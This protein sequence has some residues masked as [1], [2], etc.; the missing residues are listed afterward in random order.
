MTLPPPENALLPVPANRT[1]D[2]ADA[3]DAT[4]ARFAAQAAAL[5]SEAADSAAWRQLLETHAGQSPQQRGQFELR[6]A[7]LLAGG[8]R[9]GHDMLF[10]EAVPFFGWAGEGKGLARLG[11]AGLLLA[12][13]IEAGRDFSGQGPSVRAAQCALYAR[14]REGGEPG[15]E[16]GM[17]EL[18]RL[19]PHLAA[20]SGRYE[21]LTHVIADSAALSRW[22]QAADAAQ[23][24]AEQAAAR[25]RPA[26]ARWL[27]WQPV[28]V[29]VLILWGAAWLVS[30][31]IE[32]GD[33]ADAE[34]NAAQVRQLAPPD[35]DL[36]AIQSHIAYTRPEHF[37]D[38]PL[39][40]EFRVTL[41]ESR[42]VRDVAKV[43]ASA[44][45]DFD[46]AVDRAIRAA[47]PFPP[48]TVPSFTVRFNYG[49]H[50]TGSAPRQVST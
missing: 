36:A 21:A 27:R 8:W 10:A 35:A 48:N 5:A 49:H 22:R 39:S 16:P 6:L 14:L 7:Q 20:L 40:V 1:D 37:Q 23:A 45:P 24:A 41:D 34:D 47:P 44:D 50:G 26:Q 2:G 18:L 17:R 46:D 33:A 31:A 9:P 25:A 29:W 30:Q 19:A 43:L 28:V 42:K 12:Q 32:A 13:A 4:F 3:A 15:M 11:D 38:M